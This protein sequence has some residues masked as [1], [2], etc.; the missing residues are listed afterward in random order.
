MKKVKRII[1]KQCPM[2]HNTCYM[3]V[4]PEKYGAIMKHMVAMYYN[5]KRKV[6]WEA[7]PFLNK[8]GREFILT[9]YCPKCQEIIC[10]AKQ[11]KA[12][13][14]NYFSCQDLDNEAFHRFGDLVGR[15]GI[16]SAIISD[17]AKALSMPQKLFVID[18]FDL[19]D[20][21]LLD[22]S[23]NLVLTKSEKGGAGDEY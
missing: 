21:V 22:D 14:K 11:K 23:D 4:E 17:E 15:E 19:W 8:F 2:C 10:N 9:G 12:D 1:E 7:L 16:H 6:I 18:E 13:K 3:M 20:D 5:T